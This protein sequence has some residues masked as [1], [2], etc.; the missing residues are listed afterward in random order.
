[1]ICA[2]ARADSPATWRRVLDKPEA[3]GTSSPWPLELRLGAPNLFRL[4]FSGAQMLSNLAGARI[5]EQ[6]SVTRAALAERGELAP[7]CWWPQWAQNWAPV[8]KF[9]LSLN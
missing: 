8:F 2:L 5:P 9:S 4:P 7:D 1:M 6:L 3:T